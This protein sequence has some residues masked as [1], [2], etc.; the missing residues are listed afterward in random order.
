MTYVN[1]SKIIA[2]VIMLMYSV[3]VFAANTTNEMSVVSTA[4]N[5]N[6]TIKMT[7]E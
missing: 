5:Y 3:P 1:C 7:D 2:C 4:N 6:E